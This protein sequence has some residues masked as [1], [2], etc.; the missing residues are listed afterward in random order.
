M[1]RIILYTILF[2][3]KVFIFK[4]YNLKEKNLEVKSIMS[5]KSRSLLVIFLIVIIINLTPSF[6]MKMGDV[7]DS[8]KKYNEESKVKRGFWAKISFLA[9]GFKLVD[10]A[11]NA[12]EETETSKESVNAQKSDREKYN[13][14]WNEH[15]ASE[16]QKKNLISYRNTIKVNNSVNGTNSVNSTNIVS[17]DN[18]ITSGNDYT[19]QACKN[20]SNKIVSILKNQGIVLTQT[21][22]QEISVQLMGC[23]VQLIDEN[24][25]IRYVYVKSMDLTGKNPGIVLLGNQNN[26]F[27][28][29][30]KEFKKG[31][32]GIALKLKTEQTPDTVL[33]AIANI[34]KDTIISETKDVQELKNEACSNL[35][36][37][38]IMLGIGVVLIIVG[39]IIA[40]WFGKLFA[41]EVESVGQE[42]TEGLSE[43]SDIVSDNYNGEMQSMDV[44]APDPPSG[45]GS[46]VTPNDNIPIVE[47]HALD[48]QKL[49]AALIPLAAAQIAAESTVNAAIQNYVKLVCQIVGVL[50]IVVG[51]VM[52]IGG[53]IASVIFGI[54]LWK[55]NEA[56]KSLKDKNNN[57]QKWLEWGYSNHSGGN[58]FNNTNNNK[59][60]NENILV[61]L[62][63]RNGNMGRNQSVLI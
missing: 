45:E 15:K 7:A 24:G 11:Q 52:F 8:A 63:G 13:D 16:K 40:L 48:A 5:F 27:T 53:I 43:F 46:Y 14:M 21:A 23:F 9:E 1:F 29:S 17:K 37:S 20:D 18:I 30:L 34:Q 57:N 38:L 51:L 39:L 61:N 4:D 22:N 33:N 54:R 19:P 62:E 31:F 49:M 12:K 41:K 36:K 26:E 3:L 60:K 2:N 42:A 58:I 55:A 56:I 25:E 47:G 59:T 32:S 44:N 35:M 50:L 28:M 10:M 6:A